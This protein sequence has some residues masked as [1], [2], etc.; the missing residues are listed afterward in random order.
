M[1]CREI[2]HVLDSHRADDLSHVQRDAIDR[3][4]HSCAACREEWANWRAAEALSVPAVPA[5]LAARIQATLRAPA[6]AHARRSRP[7]LWAGGLLF[8]GAAVAATLALQYGLSATAPESTPVASPPPTPSAQPEASA[9]A[10]PAGAGAR[11][12]A[13]ATGDAPDT[14]NAAAEVP[15]AAALDPFSLVALLRPEAAADEAA[16]AAAAGCRDAIVDELR[17]IGG[18]NLIPDANVVP[19][20]QVGLADLEIAR[21]LGAGTTLVVT[22]DNGCNMSLFDTQS[23]ERIAGRMY[24]GAS[25]PPQNG[26]GGFARGAAI[27][28]EETRLRNPASLIDEARAIVLNPD[29][30][31]R[32][33]ISAFGDLSLG[34][35][36]V[37]GAIDSA[38]IAVAAGIG[39]TSKDPSARVSAWANLRNRGIDDPYLVQPLLQSLANDPEP[40]VRM[41]AALTLNRFL[42]EPGVREALQW[43][44]GE[45]PSFAPPD[46]CCLI[47]VREAAERASVATPDLAAWARD[48]LLDES[49]PT[50][51]RLLPLAGGSPDGRFVLL[52]DLGADAPAVIFD[53]GRNE[54]D[55]AFRR[56]AWGALVGAPRDES[57][58]PALLDDLRRHPAEWVRADAARALQAYLDI[59]DVRDAM[60][61]AVEDPSMGV[62]RHA[63]RALERNEP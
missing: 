5:A 36:A 38:V 2:N 18:L 28:I 62:R 52:R 26:W 15:P 4:F 46:R 7:A 50:R 3:H 17:A 35:R 48:T 51:S 30:P 37:P 9:A 44:A 31:D 22:T 61:Q 45:D 29:L 21:A 39:M 16:T 1:N 24:A 20:E 57:F 63:L 41:Q 60:E 49:L 34:G 47:T 33:R 25:A 6:P 11:V 40:D 13:V 10:M 53:I 42:D 8:V 23:G 54:D 59:P 55:P 58:V 43:A 32:Q 19:F 27:E 14:T 56:M 12:D